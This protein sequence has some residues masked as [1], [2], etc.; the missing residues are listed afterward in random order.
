MVGGVVRARTDPKEDLTTAVVIEGLGALAHQT[1]L[2]IFRELVRKGMRGER[3]GELA[4]L[5][6]VPPQTLSFHVKELSH[7]GLLESRREGRNIIYAVDFEHARRLIAYLSESCCAEESRSP[8]LPVL[9][10]RD[11]SR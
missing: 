4:R 3:A 2:A 1:R 10:G 8:R 11:A 9:S 7:A 6:D 5:L